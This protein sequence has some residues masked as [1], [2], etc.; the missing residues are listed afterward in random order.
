MRD[1]GQLSFGEKLRAGKD[2]DESVSDEDGKPELTA[3]TGGYH[4]RALLN[5]D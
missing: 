5:T 1:D 3:Q 4:Y 2:A